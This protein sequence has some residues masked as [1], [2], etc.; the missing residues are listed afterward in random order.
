MNAAT[1]AGITADS[2]SLIA[3]GLVFLFAGFV[4]GIV[5]IGL[6]AISISLLSHIIGVREAIFI[7]L[8]PALLTSLAQALLGPALRTITIRLWPLLALGAIAIVFAS[9]FAVGGNTVVLATI[10]GSLIIIYALSN[11]AQF[12]LPH[13]GRHE[14]VLTPLMGL[15]GGTLGGMSGMFVMPAAPYMQTLGL[16]RE[17][18]I[19]AIAVWFTVAAVVMLVSVGFRGALTPNVLAWTGIACVTSLTGIWFGT[20]ARGM[21]PEK[22][23]MNVFFTAFLMLG[24]FIVYKALSGRM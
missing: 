21:M 22:L 23:F 16:N 3:V 19:Q 6:P 7:T 11:L 20:K 4:K 10:V 13:P 2:Y 12:R 14:P 24:A 18:L 17:E 9:S 1:F 5:A 8:A 15:I